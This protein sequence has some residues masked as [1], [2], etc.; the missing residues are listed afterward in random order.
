MRVNHLSEAL[1]RLRPDVD[2]AVS[3]E[4]PG[5]PED[6]EWITEDVDPPTLREVQLEA[7]SIERELNRTE[8]QRRRREAYDTEGAD[9][10]SLVL[11]LWEYVLSTIPEDQ[12]EGEI[13]RIER[14]RERIR[15]RLPAG[16]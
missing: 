10:R 6:V 2:F 5:Y 1:T 13:A 12:R 11:A 15:E 16:G 4:V 3:G 9:L 7:E 14:I 8:Y